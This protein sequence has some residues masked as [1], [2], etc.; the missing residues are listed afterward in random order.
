MHL[1]TIV[2]II[3]GLTYSIL[4]VRLLDPTILQFKLGDLNEVYHF[5]NCWIYAMFTA[6]LTITFY[7]FPVFIIYYLFVIL[8]FSQK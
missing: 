1:H 7:G 2:T 8:V 6:I 5:T 4:T 3:V